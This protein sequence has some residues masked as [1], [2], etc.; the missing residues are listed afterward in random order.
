M[1]VT[2]SLGGK[3]VPVIDY[4]VVEDSTPLEADDS[5]G[6]VGTIRV[7]VPSLGG[8]HLVKGVRVMIEDT[9]RGTVL[10]QVETVTRNDMD[11]T[12]DIECVSRLGYL[13]RYNIQA[14]PFVG[15]LKDAFEYYL[16]LAKIET[17]FE[18]ESNIANNPVQLPGWYGELWYNLKRLAIAQGAEIVLSNGNIVLRSPRQTVAHAGRGDIERTLYVGG[19]DLAQY[20]EVYQYHTKVLT[21]KPVFP[22]FGWSNQNDL[23]SFNAGEASEFEFE[24]AASVTS[25]T[26]PVMKEKVGKTDFSASVYTVV[27]DTGEAVK[28]EDFKRLGGLLRVRM[29]EDTTTLHLWVRG[30]D[31]YR[32]KEGELVTRFYLAS[33][34][35]RK[36]PWYQ[37]SAYPTLRL[38]GDGVQF[39]KE[40]MTFATGMSKEDADTEVGITVDSPFIT[41]AAIATRLGSSL[42]RR[43]A[44]SETTLSG[45]VRDIAPV[46]NGSTAQRIRYEDVFSKNAGA[47]YSETTGRTYRRVLEDLNRDMLIESTK[48][49]MG[50]AAGSRIYDEKTGTWYRIRS[51]IITPEYITFDSAEPDTLNG[52]VYDVLGKYSYQ[53]I[54]NASYGLTYDQ[55]ILRGALDLGV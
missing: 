55:V 28:P 39:Y 46:Y 53:E 9:E 7:T 21:N 1:A 42:A 13:N 3:S 25:F 50:A 5:T 43:Y 45:T 34:D 19:R 24:L 47:P 30:P 20:V 36:D 32:D 23:I 26:Q 52:D 38:L 35:P 27:T 49:M 22:P 41:N 31:K 48:Q 12:Y 37:D 8:V 33:G 40:K 16:S 18:V 51:A 2:I 14:Q 6:S 54:Q 11:N 17:M 44:T 15:T 29:L 4:E 10:G